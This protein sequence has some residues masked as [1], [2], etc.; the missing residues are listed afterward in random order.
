MEAGGLGDDGGSF[1]E[2]AD[3]LFEP[4]TNPL[5]DPL[6][7]PPAQDL[8]LDEAIDALQRMQVLKCQADARTA[9]LIE[10]IRNLTTDRLHARTPGD[11]TSHDTTVPGFR[12]ISDSLADH[13]AATE[14]SCALRL[15]ERTSRLLV[16][17]A[18][19]LT[20]HYTPTLAS[21]SRGAITWRHA[22]TIVEQCV[23][24][25]P[26]VAKTLEHAL[27]PTAADT[28]VAKTAH[29]ARILRA[30][31][32]PDHHAERATVAV[33]HRRLDVTP[34][35]DGMA[36]L[37]IYLPAEHATGIDNRLTTLARALQTPDEKRNLTQ[38][39]VDVLTDLLTHT[40]SAGPPRRQAAASGLGGSNSAVIP[41]ASYGAEDSCSTGNSRPAGSADR[42]SGSGGSDSP[43]GGS[44]EYADVSE[45][46]GS[47]LGYRGITAHVNVT[48]PVLTL[49]GVDD[50][51]ADLEGYGPIPAHIARRL[52]AHAP[53]FT[54]ILTHP[55]TGAIL[56]LGR[57]SYVVPVALRN[58]LR[59]RDKTCRHP[60]CN[61]KAINSEIDHTTPWAHGGETSHTNLGHLCR[62]HHALKT[63]GHW[64]YTQPKPGTITATSPGGRTYT[65]HP[66]AVP[67]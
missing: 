13:L 15:P 31:L 36:W 19:L 41:G 24:L 53:S 42:A 48:V 58:W 10:R 52:A 50:T 16:D 7:G 67:A 51:P 29:R 62:Y 3:S 38:L 37:S 35:H 65:T 32:H 66:V 64:R 22:V 57:T 45:G 5:L 14:I 9:H 11:T 34:D 39:R 8:N 18:H 23:G 4:A 59:I 40:C 49:L 54:R 25:P 33:A 61:R 26:H 21:L 28:T 1:F 6:L 27:L 44:E 2:P 46:W 12:P 30:T 60:G 56:S 55:E 43:A 20:R 47:S 63:K 17:Q